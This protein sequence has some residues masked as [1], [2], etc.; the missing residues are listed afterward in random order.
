MQ[1]RSLGRTDLRLSAL[2]LGT[3]G[4]AAQS[5]GPV[6]PER[7]DEVVRAA[8]EHGIT[9]FDMAPLWGDGESERRVA[10]M[11][12]EAEL[13][14]AVFVTRAGT[15]RVD[16]KVQQGF[17][18]DELIADCEGSLER[19]GREQIDLWLLHD[20]GDA[21][22]RKDD[23]REAI[24]RLEEDGKIRAWGVS[25]GDADEA[26]LA[27]TAGAQAICLPYNMLRTVDLDDLAPELARSGCGVLA[28]SPLAYGMLAGQWSDTRRFAP[29]D[30]RARRWKQPAF[31]ERIRQVNA[32]RF[33]VGPDHPDMATAS[34]RFVLTNRT[35]NSCVIGARSPYQ[36]L[37]AVEAAG[38]PPYLSEDDIIRLMKVRD[39]AGI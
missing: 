25:V 5:Y 3:W 11:V 9:T 35:V 30:H 18:P 27:I 14:D 10:R 1:I 24:D 22:L 6:A 31:I 20:P 7:F 39:S 4:L 2:S 16:G 29:A 17:S 21:V 33:L 13:D 36:V 23:W 28:R 15:R 32:L 8:I 37:A 12:E 38:E 26:R 19:L 34:L